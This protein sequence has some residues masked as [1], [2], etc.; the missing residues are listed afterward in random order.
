MG[1][2]MTWAR[3]INRN[4]LKEGDYDKAPW[5]WQVNLNL[6][7]ASIDKYIQDEMPKKLREYEGRIKILVGDIRRLEKD[8]V[9]E[10]VICKIVAQRTGIDANIVA[11]VIK[12]FMSY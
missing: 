5:S 4:G 11:A 1:Y 3:V 2:P 6:D 9:D 12:E 8:A 10:N 7:I